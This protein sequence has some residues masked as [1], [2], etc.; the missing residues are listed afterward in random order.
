MYLLVGVVQNMKLGCNVAQS[1]KIYTYKI[2]SS[3][4][5][6]AHK[7]VVEDCPSAI[8]PFR[9]HVVIGVGG[10]LKIYDFSQEM[11]FIKYEIP[12]SFIVNFSKYH[13]CVLCSFFF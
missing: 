1:G 3:S 7:T 8:C 9:G 13:I 6:L 2:E 12:V 11:L 4:F 10:S 5:V